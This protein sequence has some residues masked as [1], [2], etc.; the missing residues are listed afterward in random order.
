MNIPQRQK[1]RLFSWFDPKKP[2]SFQAQ[3]AIV[4]GSNSLR[5]RGKAGSRQKRSKVKYAV[6]DVRTLYSCF[7]E[8]KNSEEFDGI[9]CSKVCS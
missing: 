4:C 8:Q 7:V 2:Q 9:V 3:G 1:F 6:M 5:V